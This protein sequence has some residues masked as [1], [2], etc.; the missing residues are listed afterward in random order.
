MSFNILGLGTALPRH[1]ITQQRALELAV[2]LG[3]S[4]E[5]QARALR[6]LYRK[7]GIETRQTALPH[8]LAYEWRN[9]PG[10]NGHG[11]TTADRMRLYKEHAAQLAEQAAR[12]ALADAELQPRDVTHLV[13]VSC[14]G[15][16]A[17]GVDLQLIHALKLKPNTQRL[18]VGFMG[19]HGAINGLR[20]AQGLAAADP[21]AVVLVS[22]VE[23]CSVHYA[24]DPQ[25]SVG[26]VLFSDGAAA[27]VGVHQAKGHSSSGSELSRVTGT[28]SCVLPDSAD[29]MSW[30]IGDHGFQ[31]TLSARLPEL[32]AQN[33]RPWID[34]WLREQGT[35]VE[36]V[37]SW[38]IHPGGPRVI[39]AV[40][41]CLNLERERTVASREVL[42]ECGNMS[43][44]TVLFILDRLRRNNSAR[45]CV[46]LAFGPGLVVEGALI[47]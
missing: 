39:S 7:S 40:E 42:S 17:P 47:A 11:P 46:M 44:P 31:M 22:A 4:T 43:S 23:I 3:G 25:Q 45:P 35:N 38:A 33:L 14:T 16:A 20:A 24:H 9:A 10:A 37:G 12:A 21:Q 30:Q 6:V 28:A 34:D 36:S 13:T 26:N 5:E 1:R 41:E 19:C 27:L 18:H 8:Q 32:I 2:E 15:F 29:A